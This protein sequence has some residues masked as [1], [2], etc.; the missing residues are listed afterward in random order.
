MNSPLSVQQALCISIT[1]TCASTVP[2][3]LKPQPVRDAVM[4]T[5]S[6]KSTHS[7]RQQDVEIIELLSDSED[8]RGPQTPAAADVYD[9]PLM[10]L[11]QA[12]Q[13]KR[14]IEWSPSP[15]DIS[16]QQAEEGQLSTQDEGV[17]VRRA[18]AQAH[19][20]VFSQD[21]PRDDADAGQR[22]SQVDT[23]PVCLHIIQQS[24][25]SQLPVVAHPMHTSIAEDASSQEQPSRQQT[26]E[27]GEPSQAA[28]RQR[29]EHTSTVSAENPSGQ[30]PSDPQQAAP[31]KHADETSPHHESVSGPANAASG[32]LTRGLDKAALAPAQPRKLARKM[33]SLNAHKTAKGTAVDESVQG[34]SQFPCLQTPFSGLP[35]PALPNP[36][37]HCREVI[38]NPLMVLHVKD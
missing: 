33:T 15:S 35:C 10:P 6:Q 31:E 12:A 16:Q 24:Q 32:P 4:E 18:L 38:C 27:A 30:G 25:L 20:E 7:I 3:A 9:T 19:S 1:N 8:D 37:E 29:C 14:K 36:P 34:E 11:G 28:K 2:E 22:L 5:T 26:A 17:K 13:G 23:A 21:G